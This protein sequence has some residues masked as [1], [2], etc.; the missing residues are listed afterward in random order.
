M[1]GNLTGWHLLIILAVVLLIF[2]ASK[3]PGL[4]RAMGQSARILK[5]EITTAKT[6]TTGADAGPAPEPVP[7]AAETTVAAR[8]TPKP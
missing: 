6:E 2:G 8:E 7:P 1:L 4:A 3:L 5:S